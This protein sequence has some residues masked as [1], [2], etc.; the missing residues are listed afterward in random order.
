MHN[1]NAILN[2]LLRQNIQVFLS[3]KLPELI[4][5]TCRKDVEIN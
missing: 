3:A 1:I 4:Y 5:Q 2:L